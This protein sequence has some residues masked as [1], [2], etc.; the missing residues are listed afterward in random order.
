MWCGPIYADG[1][2]SEQALAGCTLPNLERRTVAEVTGGDTLKLTDGTVVRLIGAK[3]PSVPLGYRGDRPW[4]LVEEA[5]QALSELASGA[6]IE[7]G[8]GGTRSDRHGNALAQVFVVKGESRVWLQGELVG[9]GLARVYSFPDNHACVAELLAREDEA[10]TKH[11]GVWAMSAYR[12]LEAG[13]LERLGRLTRSYQLVEGVVA[14]VGEGGARVYLNFAKDWKSD[15]TVAI[16]RKQVGAFKGAGLDPKNSR[17]QAGA[18]AW[19]ARMAERPDD[20]RHPSRPD[21]AS[22]GRRWSSAKRA[23]A[24]AGAIWRHRTLRHGWS[25]RKGPARAGPCDLNDRS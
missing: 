4:P 10:R 11:L 14:A 21:R 12:V 22:A 5:K 25:K 9:R 2:Q 17:R 8:Y 3:A 7:L 19:L 13:D 24:R 20:R 16:E 15:F 1:A 23:R 6:E 18:R